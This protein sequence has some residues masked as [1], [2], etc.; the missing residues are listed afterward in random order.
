MKDDELGAEVEAGVVDPEHPDVEEGPVGG[1]DDPTHLKWKHQK[2]MT[3][4]VPILT[5]LGFNNNNEAY[6]N[7]G[8]CSTET[9]V[10]SILNTYP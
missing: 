4:L 6:Y 10:L 1:E 2:V 9:L 5:T 7:M 8:P 3:S